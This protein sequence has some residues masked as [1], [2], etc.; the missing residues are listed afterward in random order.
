MTM[1]PSLSSRIQY[2]E[3]DT[4]MRICENFRAIRLSTSI[5]R[6]PFLQ[7]SGEM[8]AAKALA[9][10]QSTCVGAVIEVL[11]L[12]VI[13]IHVLEPGQTG[14]QYRCVLCCGYLWESPVR[15]SDRHNGGNAQQYD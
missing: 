14:K 1:E 12:A 2:E 10:Q 6:T 9:S 15:L 4:I 5:A 11:Q 7:G 3:S 13:E 8:R